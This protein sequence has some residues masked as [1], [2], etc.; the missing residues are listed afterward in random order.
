MKYLLIF[1]LAL[2]SCCNHKHRKMIVYQSN[3]SGFNLQSSTI[4]V[5]SVTTTTQHSAD[6]WIDGHKTT[7]YAERIMFSEWNY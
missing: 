4:S 7:I 6:V 1:A 5:D 2:S 3:G